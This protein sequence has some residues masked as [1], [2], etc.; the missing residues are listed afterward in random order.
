MG[1]RRIINDYFCDI[2][3][4]VCIFE[5]LVE[6]YKLLIAGAEELNEIT[7]AKVSNVKSALRRVS[8]TGHIIDDMIEVL[9]DICCSYE[10]YVQSKTKYLDL[11]LDQ[12]Y[13][14][15]EVKEGLDINIKKP[16]DT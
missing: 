15:E 12:K 2:N 3:N 4:I 1:R 13:I 10:C 16:E 8:A 14:K 5:K 11:R 7:P 6:S 9:D